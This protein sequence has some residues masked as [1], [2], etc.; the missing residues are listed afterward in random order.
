ML[1]APCCDATMKP[2]PMPLHC[3]IAD[4]LRKLLC[5]FQ[6][7]LTNGSKVAATFVPQS[8]AVVRR[9]D[10]YE[11]SLC[12]YYQDLA[13][14]LELLFRPIKCAPANLWLECTRS[15]ERVLTIQASIYIMEEDPARSLPG[16]MNYLLFILGKEGYAA[17]DHWILTNPTDK[18][19]AEKFLDY[20]ESILDDEISPHVR[21][22]ELEDI[23]K[24]ADETINALIWSYMPTCLPCTNRWW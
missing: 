13:L 18:N 4:T 15:N 21:V 2:T 5:K 8:L 16:E 7:N 19:Y 9:I 22:Y 20:L 23:K 24:R 11:H 10:T 1:L 14:V 3:S 6:V 17:M 12:L